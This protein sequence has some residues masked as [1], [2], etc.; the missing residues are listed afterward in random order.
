MRTTDIPYHRDEPGPTALILGEASQQRPHEGECVSEV[1]HVLHIAIVR[2]STFATAQH[3]LNRLHTEFDCVFGVVQGD[4]NVPRTSR[5]SL[6]VDLQR[7]V[8]GN[9]GAIE[10][11]HATQGALRATHNLHVEVRRDDQSLCVYV[12]L[13]TR[14]WFGLT[15]LIVFS[16]QGKL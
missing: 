12:C 1:L 7:Q 2:V 3:K 16:V 13:F 11:C 10:D 6:C 14:A 9:L 4:L 8:V 5:L 15:L